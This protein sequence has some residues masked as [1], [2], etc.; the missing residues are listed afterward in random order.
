[1]FAAALAGVSLIPAAQAQT[2][3]NFWDGS[4]SNAWEDA[5][6][7]SLDS[8]PNATSVNTYIN[9][10]GVTL[11]SDVLV[12]FLRLGT[13]NDSTSSLTFGD[14]ASITTG[15]GA[16]S[17]VGVALGSTATVTQNGGSFDGQQNFVMGGF[18]TTVRGGSG[19]YNL[20]AGTFNVVGAL[21]LAQSTA[22]TSTGI[23]NQAGGTATVGSLDIGSLR[24]GGTFSAFVNT[25]EYNL[26]GGDLSVTGNVTMGNADSTS[27]IGTVYSTF[28]LAGS[29]SNV[30]V[31]GNLAMRAS[32][33][34]FT[35]LSYTLDNGGAS[36]V[37]L[38]GTGTA[39]LEGTLEAN[40]NGGMTL[41]TGNTFNLVEA[42]TGNITNNLSTLP[43]SS[44]WNV[45][46][47]TLSGGTRDA[48]QLSL[49]GAAQQGSIAAGEAA[50]FG[51]AAIGYVIMTGMTNGSNVDIYLN[52]D[53]GSGM[54][55]ADYV[56]YLTSNGIVAST[57]TESGYT[58]VVS[59]EAGAETGYYAWDLSDFSNDATVAGVMFIPEPAS[60]AAMAGLAVIGLVF[61]RRRA[62]R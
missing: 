55:I 13:D 32:T 43:N 54:S 49:N 47:V 16:A 60:T 27:G 34:S 8:V 20:N 31:G 23:F 40:L 21:Q 52:V 5:G 1:L 12:R 39:T 61:L 35:T 44:L 7:W 18:S 10:E 59:M 50:T 11:S 38:T 2:T 25:A 4:E 28:K 58:V 17:G 51:P 3:D 57:T 30:N 53:A 24:Y 36:K 56:N 29:G 15:G 41:T 33:M 14:G 9:L 45:A 6:N 26:T 62:R 22:P 19:T 46:V 48:L 37:N 42:N